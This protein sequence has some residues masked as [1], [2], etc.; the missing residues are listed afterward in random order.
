MIRATDLPDPGTRIELLATTDPVLPVGSRGTVRGTSW[1]PAGNDS[2]GEIRVTWDDCRRSVDLVC[3]PDK[4]R[5]VDDE[6]TLPDGRRGVLTVGHAASSHGQPV[7]VVDGQT[8]GTAETGPLRAESETLRLQ[9]HGAG[10]PVQGVTCDACG[11]IIGQCECER[12]AD[13]EMLDF[14]EIE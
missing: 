6:L 1:H 8:L 9:A 11:G 10:Y 3:P 2:W 14:F 7:L 13:D 12:R 5:V 4:F